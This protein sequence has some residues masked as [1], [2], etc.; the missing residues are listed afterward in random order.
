ME[1]PPGINADCERLPQTRAEGREEVTITEK[2]T[3]VHHMDNFARERQ[4]G[5]E[6]DPI[7][8]GHNWSDAPSANDVEEWSRVWEE[9]EN[10]A[11]SEDERMVETEDRET[12]TV[13]SIM[14]WSLATY[15]ELIIRRQE[16]E[17]LV[18]EA[19]RYG[20]SVYGEQAAIEWAEGFRIPQ[21]D[22]D[23]DMRELDGFHGNLKLMVDSRRALLNP[24]RLNKERIH[25]FI[26]DDNPE[27]E[28]LL[29]IARGM[30][31]MADPGYRGCTFETRPKLS[32]SF[33]K[34]AP[35]VEKM[36]YKDFWEEGLA[37]ILSESA[38]QALPKLG[39]CLAGWARK[40]GK[41]CGRP[42]T[43]GSGRRT[44]PQ[45]EYLNSPYAKEMAKE[46]YGQIVHPVIGDIPRMIAEY[47]RKTGYRRSDLRMW[48][49]DLKKAYTLLTYSSDAVAHLGVE[50]TEGN[51]MFFLVGV[52]GL[53]GMPMAFQVITRALV[54]EINK[55]ISGMMKQYVDDGIGIS[56][57]SRMQADMDA[58][59]A[60]IR[61]LLGKDAV[62]ESKTAFGMTLDFIGYEIRLD[63]GIVT[64][65][66]K[67]ILKAL[68]AFMDVDLG[69]GVHVA[70]KR[71][72][73]LS[74]LASRYG[75][76]TQ[77]MRPYT[78]SLYQGYVGRGSATTVVLSQATKRVIRLFKFLFVLVALRGNQFSR[79]FESFEV[80]PH[81]YVC[82]YDASLT[83]IGII[84][85]KVLES[86][87]E[88]PLAYASVDIRSL[89]FEGKPSYQNTA[90][91]IASLLCAHGMKIMGQGGAPV[92]HRGDSRSALS[93]TK[94]G[95]VKS[96]VA[97]HAGLIWG[98]YAT[99]H[100]TN[101]VITA[102]LRHDINTRA[103]TLSR[104]GSWR[105]VLAEDKRRYGGR[106]P[107]DLPK[108]E[109]DC[110]ELV[111][112]CDPRRDID[113][114]KK[115]ASFFEE[116]LEFFKKPVRMSSIN[117]CPLPAPT[118]F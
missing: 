37:I 57:F 58:A 94:K 10:N 108:L 50:L 80:L 27:K 116:C 77:L 40:L 79:T 91:Y 64:I 19:Y 11:G 48:K 61:N 65:A 51:F 90:E 109:L 60:F 86:G 93:W 36:F 9:D 54:F 117:A 30:E 85:F 81:E 101:V 42:I 47:Q 15:P 98:M 102:H 4:E 71:M 88:K 7:A 82:E 72:Q 115:F 97:M 68:Y 18:I 45:E 87:E 112:L 22:V 69:D 44:M 107:P 99:T 24:E 111:A 78:R 5:R 23:K 39:L 95:T 26:S 29:L 41:P 113:S 83:G 92:M 103:D 33:L 76:I 2:Q 56:H 66:R 14:Q 55:R 105:D 62:E 17:S 8:S 25:E 106:L 43:N 35:A 13:D 34:A 118:C 53:T 28:K 96:A 1:V 32:K 6:V 21:S 70:V 67:N 89:G 3:F 12:A 100:N 31:H 73:G 49:F 46:V 110:E 104:D 114:D 59:F 74:S 84:W 16:I 75:Y 20:S 38:V 52:F 63:E